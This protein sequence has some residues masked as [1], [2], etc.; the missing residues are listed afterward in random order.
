V[1]YHGFAGADAFGPAATATFPGNRWVA[2]TGL[3]GTY[4]IARFQIEP[5]AKVY[6]LWERDNQYLDSLGTLQSSNNFSSG[7]ASGGVKL[8]YP[9][10]FGPT[11]TVAPYVGTYADYYFNNSNSVPLLLP[12][13]FVQG[14]SGRLT[15]GLDFGVAGGAKVSVGGELGGLGNNFTTW[16][17]RGRASI[18]FSF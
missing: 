5:S 3:T 7:R 2:S 4:N 13:Q 14:W 1:S 6:A 15:G 8:A 9:W 11:V 17:A 18:P 10:L 12:T 16:S